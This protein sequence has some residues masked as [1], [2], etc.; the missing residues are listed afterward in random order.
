MVPMYLTYLIFIIYS[1]VKNNPNKTWVKKDLD[2][3][4][5][6]VTKISGKKAPIRDLSTLHI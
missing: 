6:Q 5:I 1:Q 2:H 3:K 4:G